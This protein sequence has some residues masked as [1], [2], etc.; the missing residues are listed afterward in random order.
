M[1][2]VGDSRSLILPHAVRPPASLYAVQCAPFIRIHERGARRE[3]PP[4]EGTPD[5]GAIPTNNRHL[6]RVLTGEVW[7]L[8]L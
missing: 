5:P 7:L 6:S 2:G 3:T 8:G 4:P 1:D